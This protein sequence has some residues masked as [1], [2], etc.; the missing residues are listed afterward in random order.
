MVIKVPGCPP[1]LSASVPE[2]LRSRNSPTKN[3]G[4]VIKVTRPLGFPVSVVSTA[5]NAT[6]Y[7]APGN[8]SSNICSSSSNENFMLI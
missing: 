1:R 7:A 6:L 3:K 4:P 8:M 5:G 2:S